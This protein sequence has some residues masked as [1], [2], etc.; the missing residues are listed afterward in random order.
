MSIIAFKAYKL[1]LGHQ[2]P[3]K[4]GHLH[5]SNAWCAN[6]TKILIVVVKVSPKWKKLC[7]DHHY[8]VLEDPRGSHP[9]ANQ[10]PLLLSPWLIRDFLACLLRFLLDIGYLII[11]FSL[12]IRGS[13]RA[14]RIKSIHCYHLKDDGEAQTWL[15]TINLNESPCNLMWT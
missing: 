7:S 6:P 12:K 4:G 1:P 2:K 11:H 10:S 8:R 14:N 5:H 15:A 9:P 3:I 13:S